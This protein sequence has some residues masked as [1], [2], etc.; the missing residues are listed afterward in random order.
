[1]D[2]RERAYIRENLST[3]IEDTDINESFM[4]YLYSK[5]ILSKDDLETLVSETFLQLEL[6]LKDLVKF[7]LYLL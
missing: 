2:E 5:H 7:F 1:M 6:Y 4:A 3:L